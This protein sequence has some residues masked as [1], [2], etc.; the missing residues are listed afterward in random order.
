MNPIN[1]KLPQYIVVAHGETEHPELAIV[2]TPE[3][4]ADAVLA[5]MWDDP[6]D[7]PPDQRAGILQNFD[8]LDEWPWGITF[9]IG[10]ITVTRM[11]V[12][13]NIDRER[14]DT[15]V[16]SHDCFDSDRDPI[17][18]P[19][20]TGKRNMGYLPKVDSLG[21]CVTERCQHCNSEYR[22]TLIKS[23]VESKQCAFCK[24]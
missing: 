17:L 12:R 13:T 5:L 14:I 15:A 23:G 7:C 6:A 16:P 10:G 19:F 20:L 11:Y 8:D 22:F 9:E 24:D 4:A 18:T 1:H 2:D 3:A 21:L